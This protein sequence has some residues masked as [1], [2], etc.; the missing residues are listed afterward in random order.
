MIPCNVNTGT[1]AACLTLCPDLRKNIEKSR[2]LWH[3]RNTSVSPS[4]HLRTQIMARLRGIAVVCILALALLAESGVSAES[5]KKDKVQGSIKKGERKK[6]A[7]PSVHDIK[8][9]AT[10]TVPPAD[11]LVPDIDFIKDKV[12]KFVKDAHITQDMADE[13]VNIATDIGINPRYRPTESDLTVDQRDRV[14]RTTENLVKNI[15]ASTWDNV[16][17]APRKTSMKSIAQ[18]FVLK[19]CQH[20]LTVEA[21]VVVLCSN[22]GSRRFHVPEAFD[23]RRGRYR[24]AHELYQ[25]YYSTSGSLMANC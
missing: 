4:V 9:A 6:R 2:V 18:K 3:S 20:S 13:L 10:E 8:K 15:P 7:L 1:I 11:H 23:V 24:T 21:D 25:A 16:K 19:L 17:T 14:R 5:K 12:N 22:W